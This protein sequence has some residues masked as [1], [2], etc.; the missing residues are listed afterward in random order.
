MTNSPDGDSYN[1]SKCRRALWTCNLAVGLALLAAMVPLSPAMSAGPKPDFAFK[2]KA[3]EID[4]TLDPKIRS[5]P[6]LASTC[7][8]EGKRWAAELRADA[9]KMY[10]DSPESF[11]SGPWT[12]E[13]TYRLGPVI[14]NRYVNV[15]QSEWGFFGGNHSLA[16]AGVVLYDRSTKKRTD[17]RPFF[18][19]TMDDGP[20]MKAMQQAEV[21]SLTAE[22]KKRGSY[23]AE[24]RFWEGYDSLK[25]TVAKI[26]PVSLAP[27]TERGK[28]SGL[29]FY[30]S[31]DAIGGHGEPTYVAFVPWQILKSHLSP[32]GVRIFG[33]ARPK[34]DEDQIELTEPGYVASR[35][36]AR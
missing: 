18:T 33:G 3:V 29:K 14:G 34:G 28:S 36:N 6:G 7:L 19:E 16:G 35:A 30:H 23:R 15:L 13:R 25:A 27:S 17:I 21:D 24:D 9:E 20:T 12:S 2:S 4:F 10:R 22:K 26:G 32:E 1:D 5:E 31:G 11:S 8:S